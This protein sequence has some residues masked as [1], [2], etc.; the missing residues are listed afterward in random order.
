MWPAKQSEGRTK[1]P[2]G[3][4]EDYDGIVARR[5]PRLPGGSGINSSGGGEEKFDNWLQPMGLRRSKPKATKPLVSWRGTGQNVLAW[6]FASPVVASHP[7]RLSATA[8][9]RLNQRFPSRGPLSV[10]QIHPFDNLK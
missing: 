1:H 9:M 7:L 8:S 6:H 4:A 10:Q 5:V 2:G 3:C